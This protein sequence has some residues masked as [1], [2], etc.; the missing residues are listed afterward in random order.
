MKCIQ[1]TKSI[2]GCAQPK[3][4]RAAHRTCHPPST[5]ARTRPVRFALIAAIAGSSVGG[6]KWRGLTGFAIA[7]CAR[8]VQR[9]AAGIREMHGETRASLLAVS[10]AAQ[11]A[12]NLFDERRNDLHPEPLARGGIELFRQTRAFVGNGESVALGGC[13][14]QTDR[15][16]ARGVFRRIGHQLADDEAERNGDGGRDCEDDPFDGEG[17]LRTFGRQHVDHVPTKL[18]EML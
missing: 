18:L 7:S 11:P 14:P 10:T 4:T 16:L 9:G 8:S 13:L 6:T 17:A 3:A 5:A 12:A 1:K 15:D 2:T